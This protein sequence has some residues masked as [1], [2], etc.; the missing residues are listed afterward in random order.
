M[1]IYWI[2]PYI[3]IIGGLAESMKLAGLKAEYFFY[4]TLTN[5]I[6]NKTEEAEI[7]MIDL[8]NYYDNLPWTIKQI[9][10]N[11]GKDCKIICISGASQLRS[12]LLVDYPEIKHI[13]LTDY[14]LLIKE[15][16]EETIKTIDN[17]GN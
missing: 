2:S 9:K 12:V 13:P 3:H 1:H 6:E 5:A 16:I 17:N 8:A 15:Q 7:I 4:D 11:F 14:F 10:N